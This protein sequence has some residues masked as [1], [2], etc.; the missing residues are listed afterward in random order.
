MADTKLRFKIVQDEDGYPPVA[1]ESLHVEKLGELTYKIDSLPFFFNEATLDDTVVVY[2]AEDDAFRVLAVRKSSGNSLLRI[3]YECETKREQLLDKLRQE[4]FAFEGLE[5]YS[6]ISVNVSKQT[7]YG[8]FRQ[9]LEE[10]TSDGRADFEEAIL[11]H[12]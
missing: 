1:I 3:V 7:P 2:E 8:P 11:R 4:G 12:E 5:S 10:F 9:W 6:L